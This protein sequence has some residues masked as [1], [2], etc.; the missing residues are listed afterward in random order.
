MISFRGCS[1]V[2]LP[3]RPTRQAR[4]GRHVHLASASDPLMMDQ[5]Q[6]LGQRQ[7]SVGG[8]GLAGSFGQRSDGQFLKLCHT[9]V[10]HAWLFAHKPFEAPNRLEP[11]QTPHFPEN[12]ALPRNPPGTPTKFIL[13]ALQ[14]PTEFHWV[15]LN[16]SDFSRNSPSLPKFYRIP[17]W[18]LREIRGGEEFTQS[19]SPA[20]QEGGGVMIKSPCISESP[21]G[22][23]A[24][25]LDP[26]NGC[27]VDFGA[28]RA[29]IWST[30]TGSSE[31]CQEP[32]H[33]KQK[34]EQISD[35]IWLTL[36]KKGSDLFLVCGGWG[37]KTIPQGR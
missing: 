18:N 10:C 9:L 5:Q 8:A 3:S 1:E 11:P 27:W 12:P 4:F 13:S 19:A 23:E 25:A 21:C 36:L 29:I 37:R 2:F 6:L 34:Y 33:T 22:R 28:L 35:R 24:T 26:S 15:P 7:A 30:K 14:S 32:P 31:I 17:D 20:S 16:F